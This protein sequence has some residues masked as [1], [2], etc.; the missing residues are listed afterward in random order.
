MVD[1]SWQRVHLQ[2]RRPHFNSWVG[3][4]PWRRDRLPTPIFG[5]GEFHGVAE[6]PTRLS[7]FHLWKVTGFGKGCSVVGPTD[8]T[9][10]KMSKKTRTYSIVQRILLNIM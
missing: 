5:P 1:F 3:K 9:I 7:D 2:Y 4:I 8:T 10:F 6:S